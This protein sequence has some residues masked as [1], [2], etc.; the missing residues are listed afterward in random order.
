[1]DLEGFVRHWRTVFSNLDGSTIVV[2]LSGGADSTALLYLLH[3]ADLGLKLHATH[4]HHGTRGMEADE[5]SQFCRELCHG[6][7]IPFT[8]IRLADADTSGTGNEAAWRNLRYAA[9]R[10]TAAKIGASAIATAHNR[11][12]V[13]EGVLL[14]L[15]RGGGPRAMSGI[16]SHHQALIRPLLPFSGTQIRDWLR[17][18]GLEW[19]EDSSNSS[20]RHLRNRVR[21]EVLPQLE[22]IEPAIRNHLVHLAHALA[23]DERCMAQDLEGRDLWIDPWHPDGGIPIDAIARLPRA[24]QV[25]W[26]HTQVARLGLPA[27]TRRQGELLLEVLS[28]SSA[29]LT[30][31]DRWVLRRTSGRLWLEPG[32]KIEPYSINLS[33][34]EVE[35]PIPGWHITLRDATIDDTANLWTLPI[36]AQGPLSVRCLRPEDRFDDGRR[37]AAVLRA[38]LPRHLRRIWPILFGGD[39]LLWIPGVA[40]DTIAVDG[41]R[42]VEVTRR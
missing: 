26:L 11:D 37:P 19:R 13:A 1:M 31:G 34:G 29:A 20:P 40:A 42:I 12:D 6:L 17:R 14:Q 7:G 27:A 5:D 24:L 18:Q 4:I 41:P 15:L 30:L 28:G 2:A 33:S 22:G 36:S 23:D 38:F 16:H 9:L 35:L 8:D 39:K 32:R 25:R 10:R 3:Q 21:H